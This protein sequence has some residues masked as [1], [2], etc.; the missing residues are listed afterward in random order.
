[1][2][3][4]TVQL[5]TLIQGA[6]LMTALGRYNNTVYNLQRLFATSVTHDLGESRPRIT[7]YCAK[8]SNDLGNSRKIQKTMPC[9]GSTP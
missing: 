9:S 8:L 1:M 2:V 5:G 6:R 4:S 7:S 3:H